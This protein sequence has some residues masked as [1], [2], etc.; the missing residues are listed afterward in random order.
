ME[1][2]AC[3]T[4]CSAC[5]WDSRNAGTSAAGRHE[6]RYP[7][8]SRSPSRSCDRTRRFKSCQAYH[9]PSAFSGCIRPLESRSLCLHEILHLRSLARL[10]SFMTI[11][12]LIRSHNEAFTLAERRST[13]YIVTMLVFDA[14]TTGEATDFVDAGSGEKAHRLQ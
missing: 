11:R 9:L 4:I 13:P 5:G 3:S 2:T 6:R 1:S 10:H 14:C 8:P 7:G 12:T